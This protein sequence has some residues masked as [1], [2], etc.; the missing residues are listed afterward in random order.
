MLVR[1]HGWLRYENEKPVSR[2]NSVIVQYLWIPP[3]NLPHFPSFR[4]P[5]QIMPSMEVR[6]GRLVSSGVVDDMV[7]QCC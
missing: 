1:G 4:V 2:D 7:K 6:V 3:S 5:F